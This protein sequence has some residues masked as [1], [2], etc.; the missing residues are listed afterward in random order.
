METKTMVMRRRK[1]LLLSRREEVVQQEKPRKLQVATKMSFHQQR[2]KARAEADLLARKPKKKLK[3]R[4]MRKMKGRKRRPLPRKPTDEG[5]QQAKLRKQQ[6]TRRTVRKKTAREPIQSLRWSR[7]MG[8]RMTLIQRLR[9]RRRRLQQRRS[10][11]REERKDEGDL[12]D[13]R[14]PRR[15]SRAQSTT[16]TTSPTPHLN[17]RKAPMIPGTRTTDPML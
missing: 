10:L 5:V 3:T 16:S 8:A 1:R 9:Q 13:R 12:Q 17:R 6:C 7:T 2:P 4:K 11:P 14:L 15:K